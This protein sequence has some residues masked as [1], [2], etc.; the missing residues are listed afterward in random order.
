MG[1]HPYHRRGFTLI[2]L[3]V[4]IAVIA[5]L[6]GILLP[7]L[8]SARENG[9]TAKCQSNLRQFVTAFMSYANQQRGFFSSGAWDNDNREALGPLDTHGWVADFVNGGYGNAAN[10]MCPSSPARASQSLAFGR[11]NN[12]RA[13]RGFTQT[14][15][16][17]LARQGFNTN[18]CQSW[19]MAHTDVK[20]HR[21]V[22]NYKDRTL[23][24][25]PLNEKDLGN[26]ATPSI[27]P[28]L[29]DGAAVL[30]DPDDDVLLEGG[31]IVPGA[32][33]LTDGPVSMVSVPFMNVPGTGRQRY[34]DWG[35]VHGKGGKVTNEVNHDKMYGNIAFADGHV[36]IFADLGKRDGRWDA[37]TVQIN[38]R[39]TIAYDELE[40]KVYGGWLTKQGLNW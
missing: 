27:V 8:G 24:R 18:Y 5:L 3:L 28:M 6:I 9:R 1:S 17:E 35:P 36:A 32:K 7:S 14:Q 10:M 40:G 12:S 19:Y 37:S 31:L 22:G 2:E 23:L 4:V 15:L 25:G 30:L 16:F 29:A 33:V 39:W 11:A 21:Q 38:G 34:E 20:N 13:Y 26:T